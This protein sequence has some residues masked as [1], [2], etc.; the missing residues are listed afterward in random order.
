MTMVVGLAIAGLC[1]QG[2]WCLEPGKASK[3][4]Y[5][6][7]HEIRCLRMPCLH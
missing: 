4:V 7:A 6:R 2:I 3:R 5:G 1:D